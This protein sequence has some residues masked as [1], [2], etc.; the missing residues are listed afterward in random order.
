M[1]F[2]AG[3]PV[4]TRLSIHWVAPLELH[5]SHLSPKLHSCGS[6]SSSLQWHSLRQPMCVPLFR[7]E[8][9]SPRLQPNLSQMLRASS[10]T[11]GQPLIS[12]KFLILFLPFVVAAGVGC[13]STPSY[14][15]IRPMVYGMH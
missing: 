5:W 1:G 12:C 3:T 13:A 10:G 6:T 11:S 2:L 14:M 15:C 7:A 9:V 4:G 8:S